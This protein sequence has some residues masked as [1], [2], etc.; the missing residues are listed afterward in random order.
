MSHFFNTLKS[1]IKEEFNLLFRQKN[2][3]SLSLISSNKSDICIGLTFFIVFF[4]LYSAL[5]FR[6]AQGDFLFYY[7]YGFDLDPARFVALIAG[8]H[9]LYDEV[10]VKG[11]PK[12]PL[13]YLLRPLAWPFQLAGFDVRTSA[14]L[15]KAVIGSGTVVLTFSFFRLTRLPRIESICLTLLF[16]ISSTQLFNAFIIDS[17]GFALFFIAFV[18]CLTPIRMHTPDQLIRFRLVVSVMNIGTT[19][20]NGVHSLI[21]EIMIWYQKRSLVNALNRTLAFFVLV[22]IIFS[23]LIIIVWNEQ[24]LKAITDPIGS[25]K[26]L[27]WQNPKG[28]KFGIEHVLISFFAHSFI[29]PQFTIIQ[30]PEGVNMHDFRG[31][32]TSPTGVVAFVLWFL[33]LVVSIVLG[34]WQKEIRPLVFALLAVTLF[35]VFFHLSYQYRGSIYLYSAHSHFPIFATLIGSAFYFNHKGKH[36]RLAFNSYIL[37]LTLLIGTINVNRAADFVTYFDELNPPTPRLLLEN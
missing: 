22:G 28:E 27:Y 15:A 26:T 11:G 10:F 33:L 30:L 13:L 31:F 4:A 20:T 29:S 3:T 19:V 36:W 8:D 24:L 18:W 16:G 25:L 17:Y 32:Y 6:L 7:N 1:N 34:L 21:S 5:A 37:L 9:S 14:S 2:N 12:H 23:I 35:N